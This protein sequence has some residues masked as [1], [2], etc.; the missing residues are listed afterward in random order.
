MNRRNFLGTLGLSAAALLLKSSPSVSAARSKPPNFVI[1]FIDD[2]GY[3]DIEPFGS[4]VNSTPHLN[5]MAKEGMKLTSFYIGWSACTPSRASLLTGCYAKR[6]GMDGKVCFPGEAR[7]LNPDEITIADLLKTQGYATGCFGKWHLGDQPEFMPAEHGFDYYYGIPYS[8]DMWRFHKF[9]KRYNFPPLPLL[10]NGE[11]IGEV[12]NGDDQAMLCKQF[13]DEAVA[14]IRKNKKR[15]FF[16]YLPHAFVHLPRFARKEFMDR[17]ENEVQAQI[18]ETDW[19]TGQILKTLRELK[20]DKNTLV[21]FTSDNGG[22]TGTSMGPLRGAKGGPVYEGHMREPTI[23]WWPGTIPPGSV[24]DEIASTIDLLPTLAKLAGTKAP[25]DRIID[26]RDI[27]PLL[28]AEPGAKSP[29][30]SYF[31]KETGVR[32]GKW[33]LVTKGKASELYNLE[34]DLGERNN[35]A[36]KHPRIVNRLRKL[37]TEHV[38]ELEK[39][40]RPAAFVQNPKPILPHRKQG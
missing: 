39:N 35:I 2:M 14:F 21:I 29:H 19:S 17:A 36:S 23:A 7:G 12:D 6:V 11:V 8:N 31:Y 18:E 32:S 13:T 24:C 1:I 25:T 37:L 40:K 4:T 26:G 9:N 15:P 33:K 30:K 22:S 3:G 34:E 5:R 10:R 38:A 16:V 20:L 28:L 27:S